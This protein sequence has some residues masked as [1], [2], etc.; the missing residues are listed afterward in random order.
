LTFL[1]G[2][3]LPLLAERFKHRKILHVNFSFWNKKIT[4]SIVFGHFA[5]IYSKNIYNLN[6]EFISRTRVEEH[7]EKF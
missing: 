4:Q 1:T 3:A 6:N 7:R 2:F 5:Q